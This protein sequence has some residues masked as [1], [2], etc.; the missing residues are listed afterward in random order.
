MHTCT[1]VHASSRSN[2]CEHTPCLRAQTKET[3]TASKFTVHARTHSHACIGSK[4]RKWAYAL[5][6]YVHTHIHT[7]MASQEWL[8][9]YTVFIRTHM[10][11]WW[12][13]SV[14]HILPANSVYCDIHIDS[15][16]QSLC[17]DGGDYARHLK[18]QCSSTDLI[19]ATAKTGK[20]KTFGSRHVFHQHQELHKHKTGC[21]LTRRSNRCWSCCIKKSIK[22]EIS[23][24]RLVSW[25]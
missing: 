11:I 25:C 4:E 24:L 22:P 10:H 6:K 21:L 20:S 15:H 19:V 16:A 8:W 1:H 3:K 23:W 12:H 9:T 17:S 14:S 7:Y 5:S 18:V 13:K 2:D